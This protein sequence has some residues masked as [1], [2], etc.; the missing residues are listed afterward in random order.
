[1]R[2]PGVFIGLLLAASLAGCGRTAAPALFPE[3]TDAVT[4]V[5]WHAAEETS[6]DLRPEE[7]AA[8]REWAEALELE[9]R[10]FAQGAS[11]GDA[12]GGTVYDFQ[13]NGG[14]ASFSYVLSN[15]GYIVLDG[16]WYEAADPSDPPVSPPGNAGAP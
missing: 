11:P 10:T 4:A 2:L 3:K 6:W 9:R 1:M 8:V 16:A 13:I 12:D 7:I 5:Y 15:G 14:E